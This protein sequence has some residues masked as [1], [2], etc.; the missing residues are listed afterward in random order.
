MEFM[1]H[2]ELCCVALVF[3]YTLEIDIQAYLF[4]EEFL[5]YTG[6][7]AFESIDV[8][9]EQPGLADIWSFQIVTMPAVVTE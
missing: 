5:E 3:G 9:E 6:R 7:S 8:V 4:V 1:G 2:T